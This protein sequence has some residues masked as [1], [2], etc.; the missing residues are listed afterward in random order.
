MGY[1]FFFN[2]LT[3]KDNAKAATNLDESW[4]IEVAHSAVP[5]KF[6]FLF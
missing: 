4:D 5:V 6:Q 2:N 1:F 3:K